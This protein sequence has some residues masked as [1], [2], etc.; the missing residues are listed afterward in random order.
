[1]T[2]TPPIFATC[3]AAVASFERTRDPAPEDSS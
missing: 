1:M 2:S 3:S